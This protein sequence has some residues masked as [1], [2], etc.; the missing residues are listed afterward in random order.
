[1]VRIWV[2]TNEPEAIFIET[3]TI[4]LDEDDIEAYAGK[5]IEWPEMEKYAQTHGLY[6][7]QWI[8]EMKEM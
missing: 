3:D 1:M 8:D 4:R 7:W 6:G 5:V 2:F